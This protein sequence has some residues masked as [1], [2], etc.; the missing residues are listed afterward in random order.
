MK[1]NLIRILSVLFAAIMIL[2]LCVGCAN[3][4]NSDDSQDQTTAG[5]EVSGEETADPNCDANGFL[6]DQLPDNLNY[7]KT[8]NLLVWD[9]VEHEEFE[10]EQNGDTV[11]SSIFTRNAHVEKRLGV[12]L[13]FIRIK[14][15]SGSRSQWNTYVGNSVKLNSREF[16]IIGGYSLSVA[17]NASSGYLYDMLDPECEYL[18]F[19]NP[20]WSQLLVDQATVKNKLYFASGD[21]S[22]NCLEMMYVCF[23]N[24]K[25]IGDHK[26]TNPQ[27]YVESGDWT[28]EQFIKMCEGIYADDGDGVKNSSDVFGYMSSGIHVDAWFYGTGA[29]I[30]EKDADGN[31]IPSDRKSV[32]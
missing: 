25:I 13:N 6:K 31:I 32:V 11:D 24:T 14:G 4:G 28:Y 9:D 19:D 17:L 30:C 8:V 16:D 5:A 21:I 20:W 23:A 3:N 10:A 29:T 15:N 22:R 2:T 18:N 12:T 27:D 7:G 1:K 26:L